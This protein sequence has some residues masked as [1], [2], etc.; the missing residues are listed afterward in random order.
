MSITINAY[1]LRQASEFA[2][3]DYGIDADQREADVCLE[4]LPAGTFTDGE[5]RPEGLYVW[6]AEY[7]EE[8]CMLLEPEIGKATPDPVTPNFGDKRR[9]L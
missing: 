5:P 9:A 4:Y 3:P 1:Q 8:G 2:A 6:L 7:P